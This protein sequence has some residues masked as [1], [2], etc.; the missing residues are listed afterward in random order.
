MER[1]ILPLTCPSATLTESTC[2]DVSYNMFAIM[3]SEGSHQ[4]RQLNNG[5]SLK[6]VN[7]CAR[8]PNSTQE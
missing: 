7:D 4:V 3:L 6:I 8:R 5:M 1:F 2:S